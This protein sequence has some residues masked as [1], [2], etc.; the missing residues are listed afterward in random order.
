MEKSRLTIPMVALGVILLVGC[1]S[2]RVSN[3][4]TG[5]MMSASGNAQISYTA[6]SD[7][8]IWVYD[9]N[10][11]RID[12]SGMVLSNQSIVVDPVSRQITVDGRLVNEKALDG[13]AQH[14]IYFQAERH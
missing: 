12:Y 9:V 6:P 10:N 8:M 11:D 1:E 7:G 4:P 5:A 13:G 2:D 14:R 3:I